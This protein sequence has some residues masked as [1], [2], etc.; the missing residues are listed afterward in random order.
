MVDI[1]RVHN[2]TIDGFQL[3]LEIMGGMSGAA[4]IVRLVKVFG[5]EAGRFISAEAGSFDDTF[6]G[7]LAFFGL[8]EVEE[9][10][11]EN[12]KMQTLVRLIPHM[13]S[14]EHLAGIEDEI[15]RWFARKM[16]TGRLTIGPTTVTDIDQ[17]DQLIGSPWTVIR[18]I[19]WGLTCNCGPTSAGVGTSDGSPKGPTP[20]TAAKH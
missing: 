12:L 9:G 7:V 10:K 13:L 11:L 4:V 3:R 19:L 16:F 14:E 2:K 6:Q 20:A 15:L 17:I 1:E 5:P 18:I 8:S